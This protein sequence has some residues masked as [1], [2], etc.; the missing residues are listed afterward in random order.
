MQDYHEDIMQY[1]DKMII[2]HEQRIL[3][4]GTLNQ[5]MKQVQSVPVRLSP[6]MNWSRVIKMIIFGD[7]VQILK[8]PEFQDTINKTKG[9]F[10]YRMDL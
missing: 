3:F 10:L 1:F 9:Y 7:P 8:T 5:L 2:L 6:S 4:D